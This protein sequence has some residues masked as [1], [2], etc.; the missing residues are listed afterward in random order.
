MP[1]PP[2]PDADARGRKRARGGDRV[3]SFSPSR[4]AARAGRVLEEGLR[5]LFLEHQIL[6]HDTRA[7]GSRLLRAR[8]SRRRRVG[9]CEPDRD[10]ASRAGGDG[11]REKGA[12]GRCSSPST[13]VPGNE[14]RP[15][16]RKSARYG[17]CSRKTTIRISSYGGCRGD[18]ARAQRGLRERFAEER[19]QSRAPIPRRDGGDL[20]RRGASGGAHAPSPRS[21]RAS[22]S[23]RTPRSLRRGRHL[24]SCSCAPPGV[25]T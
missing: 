4:V 13:R 9:V 14:R 20:S 10:R 11:Q 21:S 18:A 7:S 8:L 16:A 22:T 19:P 23:T 24:G 6:I 17:T 5:R 25:T 12:S 15:G 1:T 3:G 2:R